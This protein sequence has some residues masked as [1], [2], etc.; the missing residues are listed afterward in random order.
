MSGLSQIFTWGSINACHLRFR[1]AWHMNG[2]SL[3]ELAFRSDP[4]IFGSWIGLIFNVIVLVSTITSGLYSYDRS[5][6][7]TRCFRLLSSGQASHQ[8]VTAQ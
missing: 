8:Q 3:D 1:R 6:S 7:L 4:G 2:H 5:T